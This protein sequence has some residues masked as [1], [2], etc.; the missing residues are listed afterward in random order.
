MIDFKGSNPVNVKNSFVTLYLFQKTSH[1]VRMDFAPSVQHHRHIESLCSSQH[2]KSFDQETCK[3]YMA[4]QNKPCHLSAEWYTF[5][6]QYQ[7]M[8]GKGAVKNS[9]LYT[10]I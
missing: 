7:P 1:I 5:W 4:K 3:N 9:I 8:L 10:A 6:G 2:F